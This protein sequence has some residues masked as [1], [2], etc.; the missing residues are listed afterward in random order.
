MPER[1][2]FAC[3]QGS[4]LTEGGSTLLYGIAE[5]ASADFVAADHEALVETWLTRSVGLGV[6]VVVRS[7]PQAPPFKRPTCVHLGEAAVPEP[8]GE[9]AVGQFPGLPPRERRLCA[10]AGVL[11]QVIPE[12]AGLLA[13][14]TE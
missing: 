6:L 9:L 11:G 5:L 13:P 12:E 3:I 1:Q 10:T 4:F 7:D 2:L 8:R 14:S